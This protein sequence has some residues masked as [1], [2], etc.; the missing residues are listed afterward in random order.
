MCQRAITKIENELSRR[1]TANQSEV[2]LHT[3]QRWLMRYK[4]KG[5][6]A[7]IFGC[8]KGHS[9]KITNLDKFRK[10]VDK[11]SRKNS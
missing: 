10:F 7:A 2:A 1:K 11:N 6:F 5:C 3:A 8:Q 9:H 4:E